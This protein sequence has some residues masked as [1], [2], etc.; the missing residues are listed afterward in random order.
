MEEKE[1]RIIELKPLSK[2][3][4]LLLF[5]GDYFL[6]FIISFTLFNLAVFPLAKVICDTQNRSDRASY[7]EQQAYDM[8]KEDK[9]LYSLK[10]ESSI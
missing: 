8:L 4:R 7:L 1:Q 9:Y 2:W 3:K 10:T 5:L 6:M